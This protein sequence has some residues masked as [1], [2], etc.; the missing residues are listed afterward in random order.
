M[1]R[2][3]QT[4]ARMG[5]SDHQG[6]MHAAIVKSEMAGG[7]DDKQNGS[8]R[9]VDGTTSGSD[10]NST[11]V[12]AAQLVAGCQYM[13]HSRRMRNWNSLVSP[14]ERP[15]WTTGRRRRRRRARIFKNES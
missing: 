11:G 1:R 5:H 10:I 14:L 2:A 7:G 12:E 4:A 9:G 8:D 13:R 15:H 3:H 6:M